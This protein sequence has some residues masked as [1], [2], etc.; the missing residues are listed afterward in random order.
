MT[1]PL[2]S[3]RF[4]R[5]LLEAG[6]LSGRIV[7]VFDQAALARLQRSAPLLPLLHPGNRSAA[8]Q[9]AFAR[10]RLADLFRA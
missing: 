8:K 4:D 7:A 9:W 10:D 5:Q 1:A 2:P 3:R 6:P